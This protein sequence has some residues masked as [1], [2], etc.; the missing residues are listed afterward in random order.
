MTELVIT[1]LQLF[2]SYLENLRHILYEA[3][4]NWAQYRELITTGITKFEAPLRN[5]SPITLLIGFFMIFKIIRWTLKKL[6][7]I[8]KAFSK[9]ISYI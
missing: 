4:G 8:R 2:F 3:T 5:F 6:N 7:K 1:Y 9:I